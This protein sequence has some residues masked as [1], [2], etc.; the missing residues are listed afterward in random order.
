[1]V[2]ACGTGDKASYEGAL[3]CPTKR[4]AILF[5][6]KVLVAPVAQ[7]RRFDGAI[8]IAGGPD[9]LRPVV[10]RLRADARR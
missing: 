3:V 2:T 6:G 5:E 10:D 9:V 1:M 4:R 7:K 8:A